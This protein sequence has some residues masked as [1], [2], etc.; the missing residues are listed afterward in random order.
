VPGTASRFIPLKRP[1]AYP[2]TT[3]IRQLAQALTEP[4]RLAPHRR[5]SA[6]SRLRSITSRSRR[7][8]CIRLRAE[9]GAY[10][11]SH[12][13]ISHHD[14]ADT[15]S[16]NGGHGDPHDSPPTRATAPVEVMLYLVLPRCP[17]TRSCPRKIQMSVFLQFRTVSGT[18]FGSG[19][20]W[21]RSPRRS[22]AP[23]RRPIDRGSQPH[24][25]FYRASP[26]RSARRAA[27]ATL[28]R[29]ASR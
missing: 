23:D 13:V 25:L 27:Q 6:S 20:G 11:E 15:S 28:N 1:G 7:R 5:S 4:T 14:G 21:A 8:R 12:T 17:A 24:P 10:S 3:G 9:H 22:A 16:G 19:G 2:I 29:R 26:A 18:L